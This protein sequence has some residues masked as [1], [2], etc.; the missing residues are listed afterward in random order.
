V[1]DNNNDDDGGGG[2]VSEGQRRRGSQ[3]RDARRIKY[4]LYRLEQK[5][6][7]A[8]KLELELLQRAKLL[9]EKREAM[10]NKYEKAVKVLMREA[11]A[12]RDSGSSPP[13]GE[14]GVVVDFSPAR[15]PPIPRRCRVST[16]STSSS[17]EDSA[18]VRPASE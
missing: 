3:P 16:S 7:I 13:A 17:T 4:M 8:A 9:R 2:S 11:A 14:R 18:A 10:S 15:L 5:V 12:R 1:P 6:H